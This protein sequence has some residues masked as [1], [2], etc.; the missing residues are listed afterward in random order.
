MTH[1][2]KLAAPTGDFSSSGQR[3]SER[4]PENRL[5]IRLHDNHPTFGCKTMYAPGSGAI[6]QLVVRLD[7]VDNTLPKLV[8][9]AAERSRNSQS[10][11]AE[12]SRY[13]KSRET[14]RASWQTYKPGQPET[15]RNQVGDLAIIIIIKQEANLSRFGDQ[16][17]FL[18]GP[19]S[20][21]VPIIQHVV[22]L[23]EDAGGRRAGRQLR[24]PARHRGT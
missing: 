24:L 17:G 9:S 7:W 1:D 20:S 15:F 10:S 3:H 12:P 14:S 16:N 21:L 4:D 18:T 13:Q 2:S 5:S 19:G 8:F 11:E 22:R 6:L 23:G